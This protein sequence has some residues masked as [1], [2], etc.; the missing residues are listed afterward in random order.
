[1]DRPVTYRV[2]VPISNQQAE[3]WLANAYGAIDQGGFW[4][5]F[6]NCQD[7]VS[8]STAGKSGSP[9]RD[10]IIG[11]VVLLGSL[12]LAAGFLSNQRRT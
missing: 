4:T 8:N 10:A 7:F 9:T 5:P 12:K 11:G 3:E 6:D 2:W 1:V